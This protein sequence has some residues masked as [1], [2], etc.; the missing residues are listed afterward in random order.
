MNQSLIPTGKRTNH[1]LTLRQQHQLNSF[2]L[3]HYAKM[4]LHDNEFAEKAAHELGFHVTGSNVAGVRNAFEIPS[5]RDAL[6]AANP[7]TLEGRIVHLERLVAALEQRIEV[8]LNG[9][10][11][12]VRGG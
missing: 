5:T 7:D 2:V 10:R 6:R 8:Y 4:A 9:C 12:D 3:E 1:K 11:K